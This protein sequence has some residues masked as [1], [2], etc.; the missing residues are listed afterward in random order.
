M[1]NTT[2]RPVTV[3][4]WMLTMFLMCIPL[5]NIILIFVWA[6]GQNT[7]VSKANWAKAGLIWMLISIGIYVLIFLLI[8]LLAGSS[9]VMLRGWRW[10]T[11]ENITSFR[12]ESS[13]VEKSILN[14]SLHSAFGFGRDDKKAML[15]K[16]SLINS[17][18]TLLGLLLFLL[19]WQTI[20][21]TQERFLNGAKWQYGTQ[22]FYATE[23]LL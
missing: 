21:I 16:I 5:V 11:N 17:L 10:P 18:R 8:F 19:P 20:W 4:N 13:E 2:Y 9:L 6:F 15:I 7:P 14:R 23:F 1:E 12:A 22:G 3:G